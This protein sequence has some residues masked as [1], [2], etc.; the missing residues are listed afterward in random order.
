MR[1]LAIIFTILIHPWNIYRIFSSVKVKKIF[2]G[3]SKKKIFQFDNIKPLKIITFSSKQAS[4]SLFSYSVIHLFNCRRPIY[5]NFIYYI[6]INSH[7]IYASLYRSTTSISSSSSKKIL[8]GEQF[9]KK[10]NIKKILSEI[11]HLVSSSFQSET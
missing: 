8:L 9:E 5:F 10:K 7:L 2:Y 3:L 11:S 4:I 6:M 1:Y